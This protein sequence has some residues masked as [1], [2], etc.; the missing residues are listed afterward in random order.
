MARN[1]DF[2]AGLMF[3]VLGLAFG[4]GSLGYRIGTPANMGAG[5]L[6]ACLSVILILLG[7]AVAFSAYRS[8]G[9]AFEA[10]RLKPF[11]VVIASI[12]FF[13]IALRPLGFAPTA[14]LTV[15]LVSFAGDR[16]T[17]LQRLVPALVLSV[18]VTLVFIRFLGL[19]LGI[20][21]DFLS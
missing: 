6:P 13:A 16:I 9:H 2:L 18:F 5:F 10:A 20:W 8:G 21:P 12:G 7:I 1:T 4:I 17:W 11:L 3:I 14:F 19:P 15:V